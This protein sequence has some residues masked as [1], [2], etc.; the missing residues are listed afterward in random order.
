MPYWDSD[1]GWY[2]DDVNEYLQPSPVT[3][4]VPQLNIP[5]I[6]PPP[7]DVAT[8]VEA[9]VPHRIPPQSAIRAFSADVH[10]NNEDS[11]KTS[12]LR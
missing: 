12:N 3:L 4:S 7:S 8:T 10:P 2:E 6:I 1:S 11:M 5:H 9:E